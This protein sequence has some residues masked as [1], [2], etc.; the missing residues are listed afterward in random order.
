MHQFPWN[1]NE[2]LKKHA[3]KEGVHLK[4]EILY[5]FYILKIE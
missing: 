2:N 5:D 4:K 3:F 1:Y